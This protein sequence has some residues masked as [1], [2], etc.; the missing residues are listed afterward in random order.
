MRKSMYPCGT[1]VVLSEEMFA[2][3]KAISDEKEISMGEV[4]R[5]FIEKGLSKEREDNI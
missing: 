3:V 2:S 4:I 5:I 1:S